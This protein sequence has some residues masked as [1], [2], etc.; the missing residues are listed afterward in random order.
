MINKNGIQNYMRL[1]STPV[2]DEDVS[3]LPKH[4]EFVLPVTNVDFRYTNDDF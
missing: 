1:Q 2:I 3:R 4:L